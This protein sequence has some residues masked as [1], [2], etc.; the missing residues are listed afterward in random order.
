MAMLQG[1]TTPPFTPPDGAA[2]AKLESSDVPSF[3]GARTFFNVVAVLALF[4][5]V[6]T[7]VFAKSAMQETSALL[8]ILIAVVGFGIAAILGAIRTAIV[9]LRG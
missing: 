3:S 7:Y 9:Y 4:S 6:G 2:K 5:G 8:A 1:T